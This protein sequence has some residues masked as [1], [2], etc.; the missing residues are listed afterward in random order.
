MVYMYTDARTHVKI[1]DRHA[2]HREVKPHTDAR[3]RVEI[4]DRHVKHGKVK[5]LR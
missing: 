4:K 2:Q 5:P 3:T 1:K